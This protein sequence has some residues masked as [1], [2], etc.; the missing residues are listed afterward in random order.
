MRSVKH[1]SR[2]A[3]KDVKESDFTYTDDAVDVVL[4]LKG[5]AVSCS[6]RDEGED[7]SD[8]SVDELHV[9]D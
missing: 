1:D 2:I 9:D 4:V 8:E 3:N 7:G 6:E 5:D